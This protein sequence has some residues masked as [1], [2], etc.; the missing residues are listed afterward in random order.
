MS[1]DI[2]AAGSRNFHFT[3]D[4]NPDNDIFEAADV[5]SALHSTSPSATGVLEGAIEYGSPSPYFAGLSAIATIEFLHMLKNAVDFL[6]M[7]PG[8]SSG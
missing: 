3:R 5:A 6:A 1:F 2:F 8:A 4:N 7:R